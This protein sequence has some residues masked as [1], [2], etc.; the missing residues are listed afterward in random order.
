MT[1]SQGGQ[2]FSSDLES[3][4]SATGMYLK[5][6]VCSQFSELEFEILALEFFIERGKGNSSLLNIFLITK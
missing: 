1:M 2:D 5:L 3:K 4:I 6:F